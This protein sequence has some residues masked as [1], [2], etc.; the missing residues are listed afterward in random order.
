[1]RL[2]GAE[3]LVLVNPVATLSVPDLCDFKMT[4][5][6]STPSFSQTSPSPTSDEVTDA[7]LMQRG[8]SYFF[9]F[10]ITFVVLL[11]VFLCCGVGSR[12]RNISRRALMNGG[13]E[14]EEQKIPSD[15]PTL[16]EP[17]LEKGGLDWRDMAVSPCL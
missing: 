6:L 13:R 9:G 2:V 11:L 15:A 16:W 12:R 14:W 7:K 3:L 10:L 17:Q 8:A 1:M 4:S 5:T